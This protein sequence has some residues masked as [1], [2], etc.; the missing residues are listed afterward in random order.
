MAVLTGMRSVLHHFTS[1]SLWNGPFVF[2]LTDIHQSNI[3]VD[4]SWHIKYLIDLEWACSLPIELQC[5][6]P[7]W[8]TKQNIDRLL[9]E[10][11]TA[12]NEAREE[13]MGVFE[14][15]ERTLSF[16]KEG[17]PSRT[18]CM[19]KNWDTGKFWYFHA[20]DDITGLCSLF[21]QH[22]QPKFAIS[23]LTDEVFDQTF[24]LYWGAEAAKFIATK[25]DQRK[26][27][28]RQ[29]RKAFETRVGR[30][31]NEENR[32][33]PCYCLS[34]GVLQLIYSGLRIIVPHQFPC[35]TP[36][37]SFFPCSTYSFAANALAS[38]LLSLERCP[39]D[40]SCLASDVFMPMPP[41]SALAGMC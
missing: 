8:L 15:E 14:N 33:S 22:I 3:L 21:W 6:P 11:L 19:K 35:S 18:H 20:L 31:S 5:S 13:F 25:I 17:Y 4:D 36:C 30:T 41:S 2:T 1:R 16:V 34:R 37:A 10:N 23:H 38:A 27:Y 9:G 28:D 29:L 39:D 26:E 7:Y 40:Y 32:V 24:S 12:F